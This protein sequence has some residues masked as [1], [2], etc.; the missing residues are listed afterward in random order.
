MAR[1]P[2][3]TRSPAPAPAPAAVVREP[4]L[5]S[6]WWFRIGLV[7]A[8][9]LALLLGL[10]LGGVFEDGGQ[11]R[12]D[13]VAAYIEDVNAVQKEMAQP[14]DA[15]RQTY[16]RVRSGKVDLAAA[17]PRL[18]VA[19]DT[20]ANL[21]DRV[22]ALEPPADAAVLHKRIVTVDVAQAAFA[23]DVA[24]LADY[25][26]KLTAEEKKLGAA[27]TALS[28]TLKGA[29]DQKLQST[30]FSTFSTS[31]SAISAAIA[32]LEAPRAL[33]GSRASEENR[34]RRLGTVSAA[35]GKAITAQ[36]APRV[37]ALLRTFAALA[38]SGSGGIERASIIAFNKQASRITDL[39]V[40]AEGERSRLDRELD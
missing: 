38:Q 19:A 39:Q 21:R 35:L 40:A 7:A 37:S 22:T 30:A 4:S 17:A 26:P 10:W 6:S 27:G 11:K 23:E 25:L 2:R 28:K 8:V 15:V 36:D 34:L 24:A 5:W 32:G 16:I 12:R 14:I 29:R 20:L 18:R 1:L 9:L 31:V 33:E 3:P 13:A